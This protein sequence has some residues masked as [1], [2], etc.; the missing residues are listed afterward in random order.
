[1]Y[2]H[3]KEGVCFLIAFTSDSGMGWTAYI[4]RSARQQYSGD[5]VLFQAVGAVGSHKL[6]AG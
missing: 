4:V 5:D 2:C 1:M 6:P 3:P